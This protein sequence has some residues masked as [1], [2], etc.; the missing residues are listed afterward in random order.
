MAKC[1]SCHQG[2]N[3]TYIRNGSKGSFNKIGYF[4]NMCNLHYNTDKKL[5]TVNEKLYTVSSTEDN[6]SIITQNKIMLSNTQDYSNIYNKVNDNLQVLYGP[7]RI[8]TNEPR[9]VKAVS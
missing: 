7:S 3:S 2:I 9:H 4:C 1:Q 8:R 5:Y 6:T